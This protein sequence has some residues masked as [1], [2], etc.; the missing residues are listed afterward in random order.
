MNLDDQLLDTSGSYDLRRSTNSISTP[1]SRR[2]APAA[3]AADSRSAPTPTYQH[4]FDNGGAKWEVIDSENYFFEDDYLMN[5]SDEFMNG[6]PI[7]RLTYNTA[8]CEAAASY[9]PSRV[10]STTP[11]SESAR[12]ISMRNGSPKSHG[13]ICPVRP[14]WL[15]S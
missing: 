8:G 6:V 10:R 11:L 12:N 3:A 7:Y 2:T 15:S 5:F 9:C 4:M 13:P 1:R 14:A